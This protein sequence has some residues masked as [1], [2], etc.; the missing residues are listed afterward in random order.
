M[1]LAALTSALLPYPQAAQRKAAWLSR[2]SA[3]TCPHAEHCWLVY[4]GWI[5]STRPGA[6][7]D[8]R[9]A[10]R[11]HP[12]A[13]M[14]RFR[15]AFCL[16]LRPGSGG[17]AGGA[18][19]VL[20]RR[21]QRGSGRTSGPGLWRSSQPSPCV[22]RIRGYAIGRSQ[23]LLALASEAFPARASFRC[24]FRSRA[25]SA[26]RRP[27]QCSSSP[28][29]NAADTVT[30]RSMPTTSPVPG[31]GMGV[32]IAANATC[33]RPARSH[34]TRRTWPRARRGTNGT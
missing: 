14:P 9:R 29:D 17:A 33:Q 3:A 12:L 4:A 32:G 27:G 23:S 24:S 26:G 30:P 28:V 1:F 13:R 19:H 2:L 25:C 31:P 10:S 7:S 18:G 11:P 34:V 16:T 5:F 6:L 20:I 21:P 15:P 8:R 22:G